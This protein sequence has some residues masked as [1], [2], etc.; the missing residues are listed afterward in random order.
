[1]C[2]C[3][4]WLPPSP[5]NICHPPLS[6]GP[7]GGQHSAPRPWQ[8]RGVSVGPRV[9]WR[10]NN[11]ILSQPA[12]ISILIFVPQTLCYYTGLKLVMLTQ[13]NW[14]DYKS[15]KLC[16][17]QCRCDTHLVS[18]FPSLEIISLVIIMLMREAQTWPVRCDSP[19]QLSWTDTD[20]IRYCKQETVS[21]TVRLHWG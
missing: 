7:V 6:P 3:F 13:Y 5:L 9:Q 15:N 12:T 16:H 21:T 11:R 17:H 8:W 20:L 4:V 1:M 14:F 19:S 2:V 10:Y 18:S